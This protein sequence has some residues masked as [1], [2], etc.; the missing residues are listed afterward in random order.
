MGEAVNAWIDGRAHVGM[1]PQDLEV[2]VLN[3]FEERGRT[4]PFLHGGTKVSFRMEMDTNLVDLEACFG[5]SLPICKELCQQVRRRELEGI[6]SVEDTYCLFARLF[7]QSQKC[8]VWKT[9]GDPKGLVVRT[10]ILK[11]APLVSDV[12]GDV[13]R[14]GEYTRIYCTVRR[15]DIHAR[16]NN[17]GKVVDLVLKFSG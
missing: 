8:S 13:G 6:F 17:E 16:D 14:A 3:S 10:R 11:T 12:P 1:D 4:Y 9:F 5:S 7:V 15:L 2:Q